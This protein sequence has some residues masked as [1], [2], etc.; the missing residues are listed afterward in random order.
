MILHILIGKVREMTKR[1]DSDLAQT[2]K[3]RELNTLCEKNNTAN[4][5]KYLMCQKHR[6]KWHSKI[7]PMLSLIILLLGLSHSTLWA[8]C[9]DT[10]GSVTYS[11]WRYNIDESCFTNAGWAVPVPV[12]SAA[13]QT[14]TWFDYKALAYPTNNNVTW[15]HG[16]VD[17][18]GALSAPYTQ[19]TPVY[20]IGPG[21][22]RFINPDS[23][24][25]FNISSIHIEHT[26]ANGSKFLAIYGHAYPSVGI[27]VGVQFKKGH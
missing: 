25:T 17:L 23:S 15:A 16:G 26:A 27:S 24:T 18:A 14:S 11:G 20:A 12:Q 21:I 10:L 22:V 9:S 6:I 5:V 13:L 1:F 3:N 4:I 7:L 2:D 19:S 8:Q